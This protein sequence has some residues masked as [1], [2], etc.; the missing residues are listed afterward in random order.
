MDS[1]ALRQRM[2]AAGYDCV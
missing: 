2:E 1:D